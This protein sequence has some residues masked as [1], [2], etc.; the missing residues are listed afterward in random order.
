L[1]G[2][3]EMSQPPITSSTTTAPATGATLG[4]PALAPTAPVEAPAK[5]YAPGS[6][7]APIAPGAPAANGNSTDSHSFRVPSATEAGRTVDPPHVQ[8]VPPVVNGPSLTPTPAPRPEGSDRVTSNS[9]MRASYF[10]LLA[11]P[12]ATVP[13]QTVSAP[14]QSVPEPAAS[15]ELPA[16]DAGWVHVE[17]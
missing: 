7:T 8:G 11:P 3:A 9:V 2:P 1:P 6:G 10:Q 15:S 5:T 16:D 17:R 4:A 14:I 12:P 13:V